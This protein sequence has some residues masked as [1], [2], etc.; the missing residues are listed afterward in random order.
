MYTDYFVTIVHNSNK[1]GKNWYLIILFNV[2]IGLFLK[3]PKEDEGS[4][5]FLDLSLYSWKFQTKNE[6]SP[7]EIQQ[8]CVTPIGISQAKNLDT[9]FRLILLIYAKKYE[10]YTARKVFK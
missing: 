7:L 2:G 10:K 5:E 8:N 6:A 3:K 4:L 9:M 1:I